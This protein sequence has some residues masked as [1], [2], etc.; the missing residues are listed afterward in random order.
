LHDFSAQSTFPVVIIFQFLPIS[1][2]FSILLS[3]AVNLPTYPQLHLE[4]LSNFKQLMRFM[5]L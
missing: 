2:N 1:A 3:F 5:A 4:D